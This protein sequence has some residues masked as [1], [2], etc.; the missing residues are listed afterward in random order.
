[1]RKSILGVLVAACVAAAPAMASDRDVADLARR[2]VALA[3]D[4]TPTAAYLWGVA[5]P[6]HRRWPDRRSEALARY[7]A[8]EDDLLRAVRDIDPA[9]LTASARRDHDLLIERLESAVQQRV[10]RSELWDVNHM[11][12]WHLSL[13]QVALKQ[14]VATADEREQA[15]ARWSAVPDLIDT[16]IANLRRGLDAGYSAPRRV[17][18]R[19]MV[20]IAALAEAPQDDP[21][22]SD[23]VRRADDAEF[24]RAFNRVLEEDVGPALA[25]YLHFL[26]HD[27][28]PQAREALGVS[29]NPD[30]A[31][32]Y[33]ASLRYWTTLDRPAKAVHELGMA[34]VAANS[35]DVAALGEALFGTRQTAEI[36]DRIRS[37]PDNGFSDEQAL[38]DFSRQV[39]D[40]ARAAS[41]GLFVDL[42]QQELRV[43]PFRDF[44]RG[45]GV[46]S[47]Y[48]NNPDV[49]RPAFYRID[50]ERWA[51]ETRSGA[52]ITA[53]HEGYPGHHMQIALANSL[54]QSD[55]AKISFNS[56]YAEGWGRYAEALAEEAGLYQTP[57]ARIQR[58]IWPARGMVA[59]PGLHVLGWSREQTV[60]YLVAAGRF[61]AEETE[62]LVDR[63]AVLPGQLTAYDTGALEIL[64]LRQLAED[65]L[66]KRFDV[67]EFHRVILEHGAVPLRVLRRNVEAWLVS[68]QDTEGRA[69]SQPR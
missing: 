20:Q 6:D 67:R 68:A 33:Q 13:P 8:R 9:T 19:V 58:R 63:M 14:P 56:A 29:A 17:V 21:A 2:A 52:E 50:S 36:L 55:L 7:A 61:G 37:A 34:T 49:T 38:I 48:E 57:Y 41:A 31:D 47:H 15:L 3:L 59:D 64:A 69:Q 54:P 24:T 22:L 43:E 44:M 40:R 45:S 1:M 4:Q 16:E 18:R 60:N 11:T 26:E 32:C 53:V 12:G 28:L 46:S 25:E 66:G 5:P 23:P 42:P 10:C 65:R 27:Y 35:A 51:Q 30:G 62:A 39:M